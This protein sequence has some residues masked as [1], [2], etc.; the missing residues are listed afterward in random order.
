MPAGG[1]SIL[2][3]RAFFLLVLAG[4]LGGVPRSALFSI[5]P[6]WSGVGACARV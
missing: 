1:G 5:G 3:K 2:H 4:V 6:R